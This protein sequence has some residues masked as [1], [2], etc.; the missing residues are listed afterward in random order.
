MSGDLVKRLCTRAMEGA[1][2][3]P[4][5]ESV[6]LRPA[7]WHALTDAIFA[8]PAATA[9]EAR[10]GG[11]VTV[12]GWQGIETAPANQALQIYVPGSD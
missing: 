11:A 5:K 8:T 6:K 3:L 10:A 12:E 4:A 2:T 1:G 9:L 7:D